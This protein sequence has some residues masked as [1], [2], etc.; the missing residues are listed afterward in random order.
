VKKARAYILV[1]V[2]A[3]LFIC[4]TLVL[5]LM[6]WQVETHMTLGRLLTDFRGHSLAEGMDSRLRLTLQGGESLEGPVP[7]TGRWKQHLSGTGFSGSV[8][9]S[10]SLRREVPVKPN[11]GEVLLEKKDQTYPFPQVGYQ[12]EAQKEAFKQPVAPWNTAT[13]VHLSSGLARDTVY[14]QSFP[15]ALYAP[16]GSVKVDGDLKGWANPS[17]AE[18]EKSKT[19]PTDSQ[20]L[21]GAPTHLLA[22][23]SVEVNGD[24]PVGNIFSQDGPISLDGTGGAYPVRGTN[25]PDRYTQSLLGDIDGAFS[26]LED[27]VINKYDYIA[28]APLSEVSQFFELFTMKT[29]L[30]QILSLQQALEFPIIPFPTLGGADSDLYT[31]IE[32][33]MPFT[34][35]L[36]LPGDMAEDTLSNLLNT[37]KRILKDAE[38]YLKAY[39]KLLP[40][41]KLLKKA[42][43]GD[44]GAVAKL[45]KWVVKHVDNLATD[46]VSAMKAALKAA[47]DAMKDNI[48]DPLGNEVMPTL[49]EIGDYNDDKEL[50]LNAVRTLVEVPFDMREEGRTVTFG[51]PYFE[52]VAVI[53]NDILNLVDGVEEL[54]TAISSGKED[55]G[56]LDDFFQNLG[57]IPYYRVVHFVDRA[58]GGVVDD[59]PAEHQADEV[60]RASFPES[61]GFTLA[62]TWTVPRGK[63]LQWKAPEGSGVPYVV[64][65]DIW[66]QRGS[67][68]MVDGDLTVQSPEDDEWS[69]EPAGASGKGPTG[70]V[71]DYSSSGITDTNPP[72][73][74]LYMEEGS[75]LVVTGNLRV[76]GSPETGSVCLTTPVSPVH[77]TTTAIFCRGNVTLDNGMMP[78]LAI[79][80]LAASLAGGNKEFSK[81]N[82]WLFRPFLTEIAPNVAKVFGPFYPRKT[83]F[84]DF[85]ETW[86]Y[87]EIVDEISAVDDEITSF[88]A[89]PY[90]IPLP[91]ENCQ[92]VIFGY[93]S[94]FYAFELNVTLGE[95][96]YTHADW[97]LTAD[98]TPPVI[99]KVDPKSFENLMKHAVKSELKPDHLK[100]MFEKEITVL[101][102]SIAGAVVEDVV[103]GI[104]GET[105]ESMGLADKCSP[106]FGGDE[107]G[108]DAGDEGGGDEEPTPGG[109]P[110]E[111]I[112][113]ITDQIFKEVLKDIDQNLQ[114]AIRDLIGQARDDVQNSIGQD[115]QNTIARELPGVFV[116]SGGDLNIGSDTTPFATGFLIAQKQV[117]ITAERIV[118]AV[119]AMEG[120]IYITGEV[121]YFP[122]FTRAWLYDPQSVDEYEDLNF[123]PPQPFR[124]DERILRNFFQFTVPT[125]GDP[126][127]IATNG[128]HRVATGASRP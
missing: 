48:L 116:Y 96:L 100:K 113:S 31:V 117:Q 50:V 77:P 54:I 63:T 6:G 99:P 51:W 88:L 33:H 70:G 72:T 62:A 73:G 26:K 105:V 32:I 126:F 93:I 115:A 39:K 24:Y 98:G 110:E 61:G 7:L 44:P 127:D 57:L 128:F 4:L 9:W 91:D 41:K 14:S 5:G 114:V 27:G 67:T 75:T 59:W 120:D 102:V 47:A 21:T 28:G 80:D 18:L 119:Y 49:N 46:A 101:I 15:F 17:I 66:L 11:T 83:W 19:Q 89:G 112:E 29:D 123:K 71:W 85:A 122:Y 36:K 109:D 35:D 37:I 69:Y 60:S 58:P 25:P 56:S 12:K 43:S 20:Y 84:A 40:G 53:G 82:D 76:M 92:K 10:E 95:N 34:S 64:K 125:D 38:Q 1:T 68:M 22:R 8:K 118:G 124:S 45:L 30:R 108:T 78:G 121:N 65:G 23:G 13:R 81:L 107:G 16:R 2:L 42:L 87:L 74:T 3:M 79:D 90:P 52:V 103:F 106:N 111:Q 104:I 97:W 55:L 86:V 94:L